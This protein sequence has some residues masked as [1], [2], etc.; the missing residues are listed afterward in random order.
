MQQGIISVNELN[1]LLKSQIENSE[2][3]RDLHVVGEISN[4]VFNKSGH[5]YF[6][7]KDEYSA[8]SCMI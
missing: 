5:V 3:F 4:L 2:L 6:S 8:I 7:L 1:G